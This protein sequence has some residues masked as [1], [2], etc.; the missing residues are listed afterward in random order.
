MRTR[1]ICAAILSLSACDNGGPRPPDALDDAFDRHVGKLDGGIDAAVAAAVLAV[2][3]TRS[4]EDLSGAVEDGGVG[5]HR[6]PA[7]NIEA[8][9]WGADG[10]PGTA[11][12][13]LFDTLAELDGIPYVGAAAF[14]LLVDFVHAHDVVENPG[15]SCDAP[16][17]TSLTGQ[18]SIVAP[19]GTLISTA[20]DDGIDAVYAG[21]GRV[22]RQHFAP[23]QTL[24]VVEK[25]WLGSKPNVPRVEGWARAGSCSHL[26][27]K[28]GWNNEQLHDA[29][30]CDGALYWTWAPIA[31][32]KGRIMDDLIARDGEIH[33]IFRTDNL[34]NYAHYSEDAWEV[35]T[36]PLSD[37]VRRAHGAGIVLDNDRRL[38]VI[39]WQPEA[40]EYAV[41]TPDGQWSMEALPADLRL[42]DNPRLVLGVDGLPSFAYLTELPGEARRVLRVASRTLAG[43]WKFDELELV[44]GLIDAEA[45]QFGMLHVCHIDGGTVVDHLRDAAGEWSR[46]VV[47]NNPAAA[48]HCRYFSGADAQLRLDI[49]TGVSGSPLYFHALELVCG[50]T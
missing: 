40:A 29:Q 17:W 28:D 15:P 42:D 24:T 41:R 26:L 1:S 18:K 3:N 30:L 21:S 46:R 39:A 23:D 32:L 36:V 10:D 11:D 34:V 25:P 31:G 27:L 4:V 16:A 33:G 49:S 7:E 6:W 37:E 8:Y 50:D 45:D 13:E 20:S 9:R 48:Q 43:V 12:D 38:H 2:V 35:E 22:K 14:Q 19:H 44:Q 5:L 47:F